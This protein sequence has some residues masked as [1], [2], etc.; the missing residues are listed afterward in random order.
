MQIMEAVY[1]YSSSDVKD[2]EVYPPSP[3]RDENSRLVQRAR[4]V[5]RL[6]GQIVVLARQTQEFIQDTK[7]RLREEGSE[8]SAEVMARARNLG[9]EALAEANAIRVEATD[10]S[11]ELGRRVRA[12]AERTWQRGRVA[13]HEHPV[14]VV[15]G[16]GIVGF[17][18]GVALRV[19]RS[20]RA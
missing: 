19:G 11:A 6:A 1:R 8:L 10:K 12:T 4:Q 17:A 3:R 15:L 9:K 16:A 20:H 13:V 5:G 14:E 7:Y 18:V 2:F